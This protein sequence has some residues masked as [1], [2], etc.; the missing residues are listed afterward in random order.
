MM[1]ETDILTCVGH[2]EHV[3]VQADSTS[4]ERASPWNRSTG[5][6]ER[7]PYSQAILAQKSNLRD[8][9]AARCRSSRRYLVEL[10]VYI[11]PR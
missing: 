8:G 4:A 3:F 9:H 6:T 5:K 2:F 1:R 7:G 10:R 11:R